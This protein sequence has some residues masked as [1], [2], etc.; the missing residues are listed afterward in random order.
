LARPEGDVEAKEED[1]GD[2]GDFEVDVN[3]N[4]DKG[5]SAELHDAKI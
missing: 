3:V 2:S 5:S 4:I 1:G